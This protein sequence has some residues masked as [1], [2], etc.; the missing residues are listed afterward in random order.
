MGMEK[1][2]QNMLQQCSNKLHDELQ[3]G[4][5]LVP[6]LMKALKDMVTP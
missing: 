3:G 1:W 4:L 6:K 2:D 5:S